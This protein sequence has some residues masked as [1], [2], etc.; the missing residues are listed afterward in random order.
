MSTISLGYPNVPQAR[1]L[2]AAGKNLILAGFVLAAVTLLVLVVSAASANP[3]GRAAI[4]HAPVAV[5]VPAP[6]GMEIQA[7]PAETP[8]LSPQDTREPVIVPVA[9]PAPPA[10]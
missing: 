5:P 7:G 2:P 10:P 9:A 8:V 1:R 6:S 4:S 3:A